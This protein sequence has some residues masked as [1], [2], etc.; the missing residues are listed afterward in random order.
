M[1]NLATR[2]APKLRSEGGPLLRRSL[3]RGTVGLAAGALILAASA[4]TASPHAGRYDATLCVRNATQ[5]PNC[6]PAD[7][8][9][10]PGGHVQVR[11]SDV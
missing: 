8:D 2:G 6:G 4:A 1:L 9:V 7:V 5:A 3:W 11:V 10:R